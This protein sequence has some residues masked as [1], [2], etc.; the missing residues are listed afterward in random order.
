MDLI[1]RMTRHSYESRSLRMLVLPMT[2]SLPIKIPTRVLEPANQIA[3][4][5]FTGV[6]DIRL[7]RPSVA[8]KK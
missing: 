4:L 2:S 5:Q 6:P 8:F 1:A 3:Y 7:S